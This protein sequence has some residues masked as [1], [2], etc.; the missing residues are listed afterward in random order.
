[1]KFAVAGYNFWMEPEMTNK[2]RIIECPRDA[3]QG[4]EIFIPTKSKVEY[5]NKLLEVG[6][7]TIDFG[8]FVSAKAVPQMKDTAA[9]IAQLNTS[10]T[11]S[12]L[13]AIIANLRGAQE[14]LNFMS[15]DCL[16]YPLSVSET[17]QQKN[18]NKSIVASLEELAEISNLTQ[19]HGKELVVYISMAFGNPYG[20]NYSSEIVAQFADVIASI[21]AS[22]I[23]LA[24]TSGLATADEVSALYSTVSLARS[25][26]EWGVHLH[27][28]EADSTMKVEAAI[29]AGCKRIDGAILG[30]GGCPMADNKLVGNINTRS[31][32]NVANK[33]NMECGI[34]QLKFTQAEELARSIF[35]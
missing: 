16:G 30:L 34:D 29:A 22:T 31:I 11:S 9:V 20:D 21:G 24:D 5:I 3:M 15:I 28:A 4:L 6:F 27:A 17:F 10:N 32:L 12:K 7:D 25:E 33:L 8:S 1:M 35:I 19:K 23:S 26:V 18:S 2:L 14:A 13:L